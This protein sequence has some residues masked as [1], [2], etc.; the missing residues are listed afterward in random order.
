ME[1]LGLNLILMFIYDATKSKSSIIVAST[2]IKSNTRYGALELDHENNIL[3][4]K[5]P[6]NLAHN[7]LI[8]T[9]CYFIRDNIRFNKINEYPK[10][11]S[12]EDKFLP[13]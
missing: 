11:F 5:K 1:I 13:K 8:N 3:Q 6:K 12:F 10:S 7:T 2:E 4:I 9:G